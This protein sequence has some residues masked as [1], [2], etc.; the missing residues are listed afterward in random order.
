MKIP[1]YLIQLTKESYENHWR[2]ALHTGDIFFTKDAGIYSHLISCNSPF[3][4]AGFIIQ[5]G[6]RK[7]GFDATKQGG[8]E[9]VNVFNFSS[10]F[11]DSRRKVYVMRL[12]YDRKHTIQL[13]DLS[14]S[15]CHVPYQRR[16]WRLASFCFGRAPRSKGTD[17]FFCSE[18]IIHCLKEMEVIN[19]EHI[20]PHKFHPKHIAY[21]QMGLERFLSPLS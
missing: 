15:L 2:D 4:H 21:L 8:R 17:S 9:G 18:L 5:E 1:P 20:A 7:L 10:L 16:A 6:G 3:A 19:E 14:Y 12:L 11:Q 13:K